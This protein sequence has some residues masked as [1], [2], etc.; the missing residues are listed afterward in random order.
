MLGGL[1]IG[2]MLDMPGLNR[3][4][5]ARVAWL[6][7]FVTGMVICDGG[8]QFQRWYDHRMAQGL[9]HDIDYT[10][11]HISVGPIF[12]YIFYGAF[13]AFW[14]GF[15]YWLMGAQ[16]NS[17]TVTAVLVGAYKSFQAAGGAMAWPINAL[18]KPAM[19]QF[20]MDWGLCMASLVVAIPTVLA[21]TL[22]RGPHLEPVERG[23]VD[24]AEQAKVEPKS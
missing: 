14:Q 23:D 22:T 20:T 15:C 2:F 7:L 17:P 5:R 11:S 1:V 9:K 19:S 16:S 4:M 13:D 6:F 3:R 24:K 10:D 21:V 18:E 8:Y 12:L